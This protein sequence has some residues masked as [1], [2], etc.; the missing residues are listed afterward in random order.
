M[1]SSR[2]SGER[3]AT[4]VRTSGEEALLNKD[5]NLVRVFSTDVIQILVWSCC[6]QSRIMPQMSKFC[7]NAGER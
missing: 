3:F 1:Y 4:H 7:V 5:S 2:N 6:L